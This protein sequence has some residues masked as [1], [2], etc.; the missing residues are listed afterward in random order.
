MIAMIGSIDLVVV[1]AV[2]LLLFGNRLPAMM[3]SLGQGIREF[4]DGI[5]GKSG[6]D[7]DSN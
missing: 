4:K 1:A 6:E 5:N 7:N 3:R 2:A